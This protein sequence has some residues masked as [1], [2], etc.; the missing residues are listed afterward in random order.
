MNIALMLVAA[1]ISLPL[2]ASSHVIKKH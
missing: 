2:F 1:I